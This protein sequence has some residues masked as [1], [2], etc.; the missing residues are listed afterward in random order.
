MKAVRLGMALQTLKLGA[1]LALGFAPAAV[2]AQDGH[3]G[4][5][6]PTPAT[7]QRAEIQTKNQADQ[8]EGRPHSVSR[9]QRGRT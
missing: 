6:S 8:R 2:S 9:T 4:H 7:A 1:V 3:A 5:S